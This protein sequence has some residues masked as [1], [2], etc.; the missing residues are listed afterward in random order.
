M[1]KMAETEKIDAN[2]NKNE[3]MSQAEKI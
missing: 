1:T 2:N 3:N